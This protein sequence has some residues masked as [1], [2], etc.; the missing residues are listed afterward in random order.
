MNLEDLDQFNGTEHWYRHWLTRDFTYTEGIKFLAEKAGAFWLI[1]EIA[2]AQKEKQVAAEE[3]QVWI[4]SRNATGSGAVLR[5]EDGNYNRVYA[6]R[7]AFTD[8][9]LQEIKLYFANST[10]Y[11]PSEH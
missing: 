8:F 5:C 3:F 6:K 7:I 1:D 10:L 2:L 11:L 9:P 4:L